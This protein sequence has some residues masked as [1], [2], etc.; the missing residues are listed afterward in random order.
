[1]AG[2]EHHQ[3]DIAPLERRAQAIESA[4]EKRGLKVGE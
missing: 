1:M 4:L 2:P 3:Q